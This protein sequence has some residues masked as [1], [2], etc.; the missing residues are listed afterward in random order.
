MTR[1][2]IAADTQTGYMEAGLKV[3]R[4][5]AD[6]ATNAANA[7]SVSATT[8]PR[9]FEIDAAAQITVSSPL[10]YTL[11]KVNW[12]R[13]PIVNTGRLAAINVRPRVYQHWVMIP[14]NSEVPS[15]QFETILEVTEKLPPNV[16]TFIQVDLWQV[17]RD[18]LARFNQS[19]SI[20]TVLLIS[21]TRTVS[22]KPLLLETISPT[23]QTAHSTKFQELSPSRASVTAPDGPTKAR[24]KTRPEVS[25]LYCCQNL[26]VLDLGANRDVERVSFPDRLTLESRLLR[27]RSGYAEVGIQRESDRWDSQGC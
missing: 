22:D 23:S 13:I 26:T 14:I 21:P 12:L 16:P 3:A 15:E 25:L 11:G 24:Q 7:A 4:D 6:A 1:Q 27:V 2:R 20:F 9:T 17:A 10:R 5:S 19:S 18:R 8:A